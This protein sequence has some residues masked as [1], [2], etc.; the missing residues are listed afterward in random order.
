VNLKLRH[1]PEPFDQGLNS[2]A[3]AR[4][5][6]SIVPLMLP[7]IGGEKGDFHGDAKG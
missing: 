1:P 4:L 6:R 2:D 5:L 7:V 3:K